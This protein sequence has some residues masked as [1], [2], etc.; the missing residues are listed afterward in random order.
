L[1]HLHG[2]LVAVIKTV[3]FIKP[4]A[5]K[6]G[7]CRQFCEQNEEDFESL[8]MHPEGSFL[9]RFVALWAT[10]VLFSSDKQFGEEA[11]SVKC[12][13]FY[14]SDIFEKLNLLNKTINLSCEEVITNFLGKLKL[15]WSNIVDIASLH[16]F[17]LWPLLTMKRK[18]TTFLC[19]WNI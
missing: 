17:H 3:N 8:V 11:F 12:D 2:S 13:T 16:S 6:D 14:L 19:M 5:L 4:Y 9:L 18:M 10:I 15:Y 7:L 1:G